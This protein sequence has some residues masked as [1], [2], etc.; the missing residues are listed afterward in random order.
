MTTTA[1]DKPR[2]RAAKPARQR[3][4]DMRAFAVRAAARLKAWYGERVVADSGPLIDDLRKD[5]AG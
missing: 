2:R 5:A 1:K 3:Q 4:P